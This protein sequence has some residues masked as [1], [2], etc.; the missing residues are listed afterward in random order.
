M[1]ISAPRIASSE[2]RAIRSP[3]VKV[4]ATSGSSSW[5]P[6]SVIRAPHLL[7]KCGARITL[8]GPH[9][10]L[11]EVA[12]TLPPGLRIARASEDAIRGADIVMGL[13]V[14]RERLAGSK[15]RLPD[16]ISRYQITTARLRPARPD[17]L[18]LHPGPI[19]RGFGLT[20]AFTDCPQSVI[21]GEL[22]NGVP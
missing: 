20:L 3:G 6:H 19:I 18:L 5:G 10:L 13:R 7:S 16:Y 22:K 9:E 1:T 2:A 14:H 4:V 21:D 11:P 15:I 17:A 12:T 8:C